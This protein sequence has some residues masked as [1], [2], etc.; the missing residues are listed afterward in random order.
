MFSN[1]REAMGDWN[2]QL[3][4]ELKSALKPLPITLAVG[5]SGVGQGLLLLGFNSTLPDESLKST[6][7]NYCMTG[8]EYSA[9]VRDASGHYIVNMPLWWSHMYAFLAIATVLGLLVFGSHLLIQDMAREERRGTFNFIRLSPQSAQ[10]FWAGKL[11]GVPAPL[12]FAFALTLPLQLLAGLSAGFSLVHLLCFNLVTMACCV[13][14]FSTALFFSLAGQNFG[15]LRP[16]LGSGAL[17]SFLVSSIPLASVGEIN[18]NFFELFVP[19]GL[20]PR[21]AEHSDR[22]W[23]WYFLPIGHHVILESL[24]LIANMIFWTTWLWKAMDRRYYSPSSTLLGKVQS[25]WIV[26]SM[27]LI[28]IGLFFTDSAKY[29]YKS[30]IPGVFFALYNAVFFLFLI[31]ALT[32]QRQTLLDWVQE[33][34]K[35][36]TSSDFKKQHWIELLVGEKSPALL[37]FLVNLV[38]AGM[39]VTIGTSIRLGFE[40]NLNIDRIGLLSGLLLS[41]GIFMV[42]AATAQ[43]LLLLRT[44]KRLVWALAGVSTLFVLPIALSIVLN[45]GMGGGS[46]PIIL[47]FSGLPWIAVF[48]HP[49]FFV[50]G[51]LFAQAAV[52]AGVNANFQKRLEKASESQ[53][54]QLLRDEPLRLPV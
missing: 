30:S 41:I 40:Q 33:R 47:L 11:L 15:V 36:A 51:T 44:N 50:I 54:K 12:Y 3:F 1:W 49:G 48:N 39:I 10:Q 19:W 23:Q 20:L 8:K 17:A 7:N 16:W 18:F 32:P 34:R 14:Y 25:Y 29:D 24:F 4:R 2:P 46:T 21:M 31:A 43:S 52:F 37:A 28:A 9:C 6:Y 42:Y 5:L 35:Q 13:F 22:D 53:L 38:I 45:I 26:A 27:E